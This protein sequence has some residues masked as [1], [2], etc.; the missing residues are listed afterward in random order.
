MLIYTAFEPYTGSKTE[1]GRVK[2]RERCYYHSYI[3][4]KTEA[5]LF[6]E[7]KAVVVLTEFL[8][9]LEVK[10]SDYLCMNKKLSIRDI[11][12]HSITSQPGLFKV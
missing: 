6:K 1:R 5:G 7:S 8:Q 9:G 4:D 11:P 10:A 2:E 12:M 3:I